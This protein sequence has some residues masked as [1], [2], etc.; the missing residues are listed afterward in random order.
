MGEIIQDLWGIAAMSLKVGWPL[1]ITALGLAG[2]A[3]FGD[4]DK[5]K[6]AGGWALAFV[7]LVLLVWNLKR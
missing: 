6:T 3:F 5:M 1:L 4:N 2:V 7:G